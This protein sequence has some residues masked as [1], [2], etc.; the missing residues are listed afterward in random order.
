MSRCEWLQFSKAK[1][2]FAHFCTK[3][4]PHNDPSLNFDLN[5]IQVVKEVE[6]LGVTFENKLSFV[7]HIKMLKEK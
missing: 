5:Q 1:T 6:F 3:H 4:E 7:E 2:A